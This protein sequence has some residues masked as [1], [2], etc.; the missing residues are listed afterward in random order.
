M[1]AVR[2]MVQIFSGIAQFL[3]VACLFTIIMFD[4]KT[5]LNCQL[6]VIVKILSMFRSL[7]KN[8]FH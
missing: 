1:E 4:V 7:F 8:A 6:T 5:T 2:G 3:T